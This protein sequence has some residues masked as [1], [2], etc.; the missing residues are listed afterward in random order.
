MH[1][2]SQ[3][4]PAIEEVQLQ[5]ELALRSRDVSAHR[6]HGMRPDVLDGRERPRP[7]VLQGRSDRPQEAELEIAD[8]GTGRHQVGDGAGHR[9]ERVRAG[10]IGSGP[11]QVG[12]RAQ[13]IHEEGPVRESFF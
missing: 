12:E 11:R 5:G 1:Y 3:T 10:G 9:M 4:H 8:L 7:H 13:R 2:A 6:H